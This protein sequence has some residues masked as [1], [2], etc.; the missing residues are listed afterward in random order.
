M[1]IS[2]A[3]LNP[4]LRYIDENFGS[5]NNLLGVRANGIS[6]GFPPRLQ[7]Y[8]ICL[9]NTPFSERCD[10][11]VRGLG[12]LIPEGG[13]TEYV[14]HIWCSFENGDEPVDGS[15]SSHII[16]QNGDLMGFFRYKMKRSNYGYAVSATTLLSRSY[17]HMHVDETGN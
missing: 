14:R 8:D 9:M 10:G 4:G 12:E 15:C 11:Q 3:K 16:H 6:P 7:A 17:V 5:T 1:D 13:D 2:F